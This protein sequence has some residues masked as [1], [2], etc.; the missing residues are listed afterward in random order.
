[1]SVG[2][3]PGIYRHYKGG[4]YNVISTCTL[5]KPS[6]KNITKLVFYKT[7][8]TDNF[9]LRPIDM[10]LENVDD[11]IPRFTFIQPDTEICDKK[12]FVALHTEEEI[13]Y[14]VFQCL[15]FWGCYKI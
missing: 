4:L 7:H 1:M 11:N 6:E 10:F 9:W 2:V 5:V 8:K 12:E 3:K 13:Y 14:K 15:Q